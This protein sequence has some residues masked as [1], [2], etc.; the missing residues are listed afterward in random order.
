MQIFMQMERG[1]LPQSR[2]DVDRRRG[3]DRAV[4]FLSCVIVGRER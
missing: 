2:H 1:V 4:L 3:P